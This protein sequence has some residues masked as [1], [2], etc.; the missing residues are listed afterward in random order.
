MHS[1]LANVSCF[2]VNTSHQ[3]HV[4]APAQ[5]GFTPELLRGVAAKQ[6]FYKNGPWVGEYVSC[7]SEYGCEITCG[8]FVDGSSRACRLAM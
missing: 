3:V 2:A 6:P 5:S 1:H 4:V 7:F 8:Q